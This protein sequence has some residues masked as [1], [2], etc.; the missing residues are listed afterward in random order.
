MNPKTLKSVYKKINKQELKSEKI[1]LALVK[2]FKSNVD[3]L[4]NEFTSLLKEQIRLANDIQQSENKLQSL[5]KQFEGLNTDA[6]KIEQSFKELGVDIDANTD[7]Y[8]S[9][10][11][12]RTRALDKLIQKSQKSYQAI[13]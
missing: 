3:K 1:E 9:K 7:L 6:N 10:L 5:K 11:D 13:K 2:D 12:T 8:I 4:E